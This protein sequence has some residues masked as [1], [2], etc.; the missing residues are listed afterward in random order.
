MR[1]ARAVFNLIQF[2][3]FVVVAPA[4][5]QTDRQTNIG[6]LAIGSRHAVRMRNSKQQTARPAG[7]PGS[8]AL[9]N[10]RV[11]GAVG[12]GRRRVNAPRPQRTAGALSYGAAAET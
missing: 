5:G 12:R 2:L 1:A 8:V 6:G 3:L 7:A 4:D 9:R 10:R 11:A